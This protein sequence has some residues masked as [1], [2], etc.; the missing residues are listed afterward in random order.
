MGRLLRHQAPSAARWASTRHKALDNLIT[1][2]G[3]HSPLILDNLGITVS[4]TEANEKYAA[5]IGVAAKSLT[6]TQKRLRL[7]S[8]GDAEDR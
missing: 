1:G 8:G 7:L 6:D 4:A 3:R 5:S 2:L